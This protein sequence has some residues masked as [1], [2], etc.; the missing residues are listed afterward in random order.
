MRVRVRKIEIGEM[1]GEGE[2]RRWRLGRRRL[3]SEM[4]GESEIVDGG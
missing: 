3:R 2:D 4:E 1:E